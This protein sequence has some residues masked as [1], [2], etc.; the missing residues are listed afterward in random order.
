MTTYSITSLEAVNRILRVG[1]INPVTSTTPP[2][3]RYTALAVAIL[4]EEL[5]RVLTFGW[6]FNTDYNYQL[7]AVLGQIAVPADAL[8]IDI[9]PQNSNGK[10]IVD[11]NGYLY[12][13]TN[14]TATFTESYIK[15]TVVRY[16]TFDNCPLE[17]QEYIITC[18]QLE[19]ASKATVDQATVYNIEKTKMDRWQAL[20]RADTTKDSLNT[21]N[22]YPIN[23][24]A[25][26]WPIIGHESQEQW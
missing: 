5:V 15:A 24:I 1:Q 4:E 7:N 16:V 14:N 3:D 18:A 13:R 6:Y 26:T 11:R 10:D 23:Q 8:S 2:I 22:R 19:F 17:I 20:K 12:D 21:Q 9:E 25:R